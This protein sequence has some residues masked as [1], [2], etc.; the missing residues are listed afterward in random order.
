MYGVL[1]NFENLI[2]FTFLVNS[3]IPKGIINKAKR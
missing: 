2:L 3:L 1:E